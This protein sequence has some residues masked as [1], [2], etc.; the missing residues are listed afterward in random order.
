MSSIFNIYQLQIIKYLLVFHLTSHLVSYNTW[1]VS[2]A[3]NYEE[4]DTLKALFH[5]FKSGIQQLCWSGCHP[6]QSEKEI[7]ILLLF[8]Q[9]L[10][11]LDSVLNGFTVSTVLCLL[12][13]LS[14]M[15]VLYNCGMRFP[16]LQ[17]DD[18]I[19]STAAITNSI[20]KQ[21]LYSLTSHC[22]VFGW[23]IITFLSMWHPTLNVTG[24]P[25]MSGS[26]WTGKWMEKLVTEGLNSSVSQLGSSGL[27]LWFF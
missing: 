24:M 17:A 20:C 23:S 19:S 26:M 18:A 10:M 6:G 9:N 25:P 22:S 3:V 14:I 1:F 2:S 4:L 21:K 8:S 5:L 15:P 16:V 11:G 7:H 12:S 27:C 13:S